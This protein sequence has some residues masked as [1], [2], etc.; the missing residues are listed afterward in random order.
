[1]YRR[2]SGDRERAPAHMVAIGCPA[3]LAATVRTTFHSFVAASWLVIYHI[4][5]GI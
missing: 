5:H 4:K 1:M 2:D 3:R